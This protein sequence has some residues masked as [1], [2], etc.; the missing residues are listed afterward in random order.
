VDIFLFGGYF[1]TKNV[2]NYLERIKNVD[3]SMKQTIDAE[4]SALKSIALR[5]DD[6]SEQDLVMEYLNAIEKTVAKAKEDYLNGNAS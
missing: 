5:S 3:A 1:M 6:I 2:R 4:V